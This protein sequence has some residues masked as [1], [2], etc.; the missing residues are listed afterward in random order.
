MT[1]KEQRSWDPIT[2]F[3]SANASRVVVKVGERSS[4][5]PTMR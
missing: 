4:Q 3:R 2:P 1:D 5:T